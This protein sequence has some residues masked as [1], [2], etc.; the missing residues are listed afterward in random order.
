MIALLREALAIRKQKR[1]KEADT[2]ERS[3]IAKAFNDRFTFRFDYFKGEGLWG[4]M[5]WMCPE[6]NAIH[7]TLGHSFLSGMQYPAC[8]RHA[9][10]HRCCDNIRYL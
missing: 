6:C 8:C 2:K 1:E 3:A 5:A 4:G 9:E 7:K 10:G